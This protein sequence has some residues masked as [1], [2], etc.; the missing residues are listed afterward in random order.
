MSANYIASTPFLI[1]NGFAIEVRSIPGAP[2]T[3]GT[4]NIPVMVPTYTCTPIQ[5]NLDNSS[6]K[7]QATLQTTTLTCKSGLTP[8]PITYNVTNV[9][10]PDGYYVLNLSA[11]AK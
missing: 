7:I 9:S 2:A 1:Q 6:R 10:G 3:R 8:T 11:A 5:I 4:I